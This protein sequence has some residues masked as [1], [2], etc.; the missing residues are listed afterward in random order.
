MF[1]GVG[2]FSNN[3]YARNTGIPDDDE[4]SGRM[5]NLLRGLQ[6]LGEQGTNFHIGIPGDASTFEIGIFDGDQGGKWDPSGTDQAWFTLYADPLMTGNTNPADQIIQWDGSTMPDGDWFSNNLAQDAR[7][8]TPGGHYGY[9]LEAT[10]QSSDSA[11]AMNNFKVRASGEVYALAGS[12]YGFI[13]YLPDDPHPEIFSPSTYDGMWKFYLDV[14]EPTDYI[15]LWS[16]DF[17]LWTDTEDWNTP[18]FPPFDYP[19]TTKAEGANPGMPKDGFPGGSLEAPPAIMQSLTSPDGSWTAYDYDPSGNR[20][21]ELFRI[22][23]LSDGTE[24]ALVASLPAG[25][26]QWTIYG[27]DARNTIFVRSDY[28]MQTSPIPEPTTVSLFGSGLFGLAYRKF[29]K[30]KAKRK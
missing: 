4:N 1:T 2:L 15:D 18:D 24:D 9:N 23:A 7:A 12:K 26:Y 17:D 20:E 28:N 16:G 6:S 21:W 8:L 29:K 11:N 3:V 30:R 13:G 27:A 22:R 14:K 5:V 19:S 25:W 10:W